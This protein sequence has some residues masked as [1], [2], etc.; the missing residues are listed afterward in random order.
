[1][2]NN[3]ICSAGGDSK[4]VLIVNVS[5]SIGDIQETLATLNFASR[6]RNVEISLGNRDT[7]KKWRDMVIF[8]F[9]IFEI[10]RNLVGNADVFNNVLLVVAAGETTLLSAFVF[11]FF[12]IM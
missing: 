7:I 4:A 11:R 12:C 2:F 8:A 1:M 10:S 9:M 5:P 6:A 3:I